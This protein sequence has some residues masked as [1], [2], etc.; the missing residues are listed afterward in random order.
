MML[1]ISAED[2]DSSRCRPKA[3]T[4]F[5]GRRFLR[6]CKRRRPTHYP[7]G[8]KMLLGSASYYAE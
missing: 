7:S 8:R 2:F 4:F 5:D 6:G 1:Y 3:G